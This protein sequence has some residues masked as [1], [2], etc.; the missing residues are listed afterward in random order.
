MLNI[1]DLSLFQR[2]QF[3]TVQ[4]FVLRFYWP[5]FVRLYPLGSTQG[6]TAA[7]LVDRN[8]NQNSYFFVLSAPVTTQIATVRLNI[9]IKPVLQNVDVVRLRPHLY[10]F[11]RLFFTHLPQYLSPI[12]FIFPYTSFLLDFGANTIGDRHLRFE[13][14]KLFVSFICPL[15]P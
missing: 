11:D 12:L 2:V 15:M 8:G 3:G 13:W 1:N 7:A 14:D 10:A 4:L 6:F 5:G 9:R